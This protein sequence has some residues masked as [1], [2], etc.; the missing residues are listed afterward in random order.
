MKNDKSQ[1]PTEEIVGT[2]VYIET[3][4]EIPGWIVRSG[5]SG[6]FVERDKIVT[7]FHG[8]AGNTKMAVTHVDTG[9]VYT[10]EGTPVKS[11]RSQTSESSDLPHARHRKSCPWRTYRRN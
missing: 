11:E 1:Q 5:G 8:L 2:V 6:F 4:I 9:T 10:I 3:E 7:C